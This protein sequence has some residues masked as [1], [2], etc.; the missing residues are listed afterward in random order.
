MTEVRCNRQHHEFDGVDL[1]TKQRQ[2]I[3]ARAPEM[4]TDTIRSLGSGRFY[5]RSAADSAKM[6]LVDLSKDRSVNTSK[7][8][9]IEHGK[10]SCDCPDWP[11]VRL[12]KHIAAT[13]HFFAG[14]PDTRPALDSVP[15]RSQNA[16]LAVSSVSNTAVPILENLISVSK[17]LLSNGPP[18]LPGTVRSLW[19]VE[20]HLTAVAQSSRASQSPLPDRETLLPIQRTW[21]E[22]AE[23]MGAKRQKRSH[24]TD[25]PVPATDRIGH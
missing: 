14:T 5:V 18:S 21:T 10:D 19:L 12:C 2:Q 11:R 17:E 3:L 6:Y 8:Y 9:L 24:P 1:A 16:L 7:S 4:S 23:Q 15:E 13:A 22:T 20:S 25:V